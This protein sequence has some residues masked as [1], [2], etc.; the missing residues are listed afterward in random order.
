MKPVNNISKSSSILKPF[1]DAHFDLTSHFKRQLVKPPILH[2]EDSKILAPSILGVLGESPFMRQYFDKPSQIV[3]LAIKESIL[4]PASD[5]LLSAREVLDRD[6]IETSLEL[7]RKR[8]RYPLRELS[9][10]NV[11]NSKEARENLVESHCVGIVE[12]ANKIL[13]S[14]LRNLLTKNNKEQES[15]DSLAEMFKSTQNSDKRTVSKLIFSNEKLSNAREFFEN[16]GIKLESVDKSLELHKNTVLEAQNKRASFQEKINEVQELE[17][18]FGIDRFKAEFA[19][20]RLLYAVE[21]LARAKLVGVGFSALGDVMTSEEFASV[22]EDAFSRNFDKSAG[23]LNTI[24]GKQVITTILGAAINSSSRNKDG[25][26]GRYM[27]ACDTEFHDYLKFFPRVVATFVAGMVASAM[28]GESEDQEASLAESLTRDFVKISARFLSGS[29]IAMRMLPKDIEDLFH[30]VCNSVEEKDLE[31]ILETVLESEEKVNKPQINILSQEQINILTSDAVEEVK[32]S[33]IE[34]APVSE[35]ESEPEINISKP[36]KILVASYDDNSYKERSPEIVPIE[37]EEVKVSEIDAVP[38]PDLRKIE[39][40]VDSNIKA[41]ESSVVKENKDKML[42][43]IRQK[44]SDRSSTDDL[45]SENKANVNS[46]DEIIA[47]KKKKD[48]MLEELKRKS[49]GDIEEAPEKAI[50]KVDDI[51]EEKKKKDLMLEELKTKSSSSIGS[52]S[53]ANINSKESGLSKRVELEKIDTEFTYSKN[54]ETQADP[55]SVAELCN[56]PVAECEEE[57]NVH[58]LTSSD[59]KDTESPDKAPKI[60]S[61]E[62]LKDITRSH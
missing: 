39:T 40:V 8:R 48:T 24:L 60:P 7:E 29:H 47:D 11:F 31:P 34:A 25:T 44:I 45:I 38:S 6:L 49:S 42:E 22:S 58:D 14:N 9:V 5:S 16:E 52:Q 2:K 27:I 54:D 36:D 62:T 20:V 35:I 59:N 18:E 13:Q 26:K 3:N 17:D 10:Y 19:K 46:E 51:S 43:E 33:Q 15:F 12:E 37:I 30:K 61:A 23:E 21:W 50:E 41:D 56:S 55:Q 53:D 28:L 32:D 57:D 1:L 4:K